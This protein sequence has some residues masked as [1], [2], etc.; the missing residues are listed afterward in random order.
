VSRSSTPVMWVTAILLTLFTAYFVAESRLASRRR[1]RIRH[2]IHVNGTRGK[3]SVTRLVAAALRAGGIRT[4]AKTTGSSPCFIY[5][6]GSETLIRRVGSPNIKEQLKV[7]R[8]V[9]GIAPDVLVLECMALQP[10]TQWIS[11]HRMVKATIGVVTNVRA[12]H[13]DVMGPEV[14]D[15]ERAFAGMVPT[16]ATF[17]TAEPHHNLVLQLAAREQGSRYVQV[18]SEAISA[19][20]SEEMAGFSYLEHEENVALSLTVAA[21]LG[22]PRGLALAGMYQATP[23]SG[24]LRVDR[25]EFYG[26]AITWINAFAANDPDSYRIIW[27][28]VQERFPGQEHALVVVNCRADRPDRSRQ[29]GE[30]APEMDHVDRFV[31]V[32]TGTE[33]F[34]RAAMLSGVRADRLY[35]M[36]SE[37]IEKVFERLISWSGRRALVLGVGNIKGT[38]KE[39]DE[40]F[41]NR[42]ILSDDERGTGSMAWKI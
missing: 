18:G 26:R 38:G 28:R 11:E 1:A 21:E 8:W 24:A 4:V 10:Y 40:Y 29:L 36:A 15:V 16:G 5:P 30:L 34:A 39:L 23:D 12:D 2:R 22:V 32:G 35:A 19:V 42:S 9:A 6:D 14:E 3:S 37:P 41:R 33:A 20:T 7:L 13:L 31:L 25:L 17:V 27:R